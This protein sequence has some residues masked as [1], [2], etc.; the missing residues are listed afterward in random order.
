MGLFRRRFTTPGAPPGTV[1]PC[2]DVH[3]S[4][5]RLLV[6]DSERLDESEPDS[7]DAVELPGDPECVTWIDVRGLGDGGLVQAL[8]KR[9]GMHPLAISDVVNVGQRPKVEAYDD[10]IF[11][12]LRATSLENEELHWK[13]VSLFLTDDCLT[14]FQET[15]GDCLMPLRERLRVARQ[16][17]RCGREDYLACMVIDTIVDAYFPLLEHYGDRLEELEGQVLEGVDPSVLAPLYSIR[18]DLASLRHAVWPLRDALSHLMRDSEGR[19]TET[20]RVYLRDTADHVVQMIEVLESYRELA[21]G[22]VELH[23]SKVGQKTNEVMRTLTVVATIFIPLT[24]F[25]GVYGMNFDT[26]VPGNLPE[27][28]W[29]HGYLLFWLVCLATGGTMLILFRRLG[30]LGGGSAPR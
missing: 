17:I 11:V 1:A 20:S 7:I 15:D 3:P 24:F 2:E 23:L 5:L 13:Q 22:L 12:V 30:W 28:G 16:R 26:S 10:G 29:R 27:L 19:V 6:Y 21:A 8:G 4:R 14:T 9:L 25:A 18:R